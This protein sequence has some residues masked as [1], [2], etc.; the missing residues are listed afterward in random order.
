[1]SKAVIAGE[2]TTSRAAQDEGL[3]FPSLFAFLALAAPL[4]LFGISFS[5]D[6]NSEHQELKILL[7]KS[8]CT[9]KVCPGIPRHSSAF[10][11]TVA[12]ALAIRR[13]VKTPRAI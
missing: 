2:D 13:P 3:C 1:M 12:L 4:R 7:K 10:L 9:S 5:F 11:K 6:H 8:F